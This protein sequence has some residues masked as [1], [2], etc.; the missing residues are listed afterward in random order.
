M[1]AE[2]M[3]Q[4]WRRGPDGA[5]IVGS[6]RQP[7]TNEE[8]VRRYTASLSWNETAA[9]LAGMGWGLFQS[10]EWVADTVRRLLPLRMQRFESDAPT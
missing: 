4:H 6:D 9:F 1:S 3:V 10:R 5:P 2:P 7:L 8:I